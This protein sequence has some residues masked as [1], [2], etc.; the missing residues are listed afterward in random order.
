MAAS[1]KWWLQSDHPEVF[2]SDSDNDEDVCLVC[3][4]ID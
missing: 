4:E 3:G 1:D 2:E